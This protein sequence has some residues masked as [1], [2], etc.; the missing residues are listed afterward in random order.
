MSLLP[1]GGD[2][3]GVTT[4]GLAFPLSDEPLAL[5]STRGVSNVIGRRGA[6]VA[7]RRGLLL[8]IE[9]PATL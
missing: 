5:G 6:T 9:S 7:V 2:V 1:Q 3:E 8:V 4:D